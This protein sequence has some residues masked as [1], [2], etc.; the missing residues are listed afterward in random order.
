[1]T[2]ER[3]ERQVVR[4]LDEAE[5]AVV[6]RDWGKVRQVATSALVLNPAN[7]DAKAF[8]DAA[9]RGIVGVAAEGSAAQ[10]ILLS[11]ARVLIFSVLSAGLYIFYWSY[12]TWKQLKAET[13]DDHYPVWHALTIWIP[14]YNLFQIHSISR[15]FR[16]RSGKRE[17]R[18]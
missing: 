12:L 8:L 5:A 1:M 16:N 6:S 18:A 7:P 3:I 11:P 2:S 9:E 10:K 4:L 14:L 15:L 17:L 13:R